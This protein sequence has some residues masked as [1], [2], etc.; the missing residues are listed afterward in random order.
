MRNFKNIFQKSVDNLRNMVYYRVKG[1]EI[2]QIDIKTEDKN[3]I[4]VDI[5]SAILLLPT[6]F[7]MFYVVERI[8]NKYVQKQKRAQKKRIIELRRRELALELAKCA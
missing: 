2:S 7:F 6:L 8:I 3:M 5:I 4:I 1:T